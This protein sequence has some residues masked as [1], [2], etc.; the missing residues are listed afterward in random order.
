[1]TGLVAH[2]LHQEERELCWAAGLFEGEGTITIAVR[3]QDDTYRLLCC[4][5]NTDEQVIDFF[6]QRWGG[7]KQPFYGADRGNRQPGWNWTVTAWRA[8]HFLVDLEPFLVTDRVRRKLDL[9]LAFRDR[10]SSEVRVQR[11]AGYKAAQRELYLE[12]RGL[13][14]RGLQATT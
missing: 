1:M 7:W 4:V 12:M 11:Q 9:A 6:H 13:N 10:Q 8:A 3:N 14:Q 5:G 2:D